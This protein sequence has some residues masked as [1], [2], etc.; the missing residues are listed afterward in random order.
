MPPGSGSASAL[1]DLGAIW[2]EMERAPVVVQPSR[3][4]RTLKNPSSSP[5]RW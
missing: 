2:E 3:H 5:S 4:W 1:A